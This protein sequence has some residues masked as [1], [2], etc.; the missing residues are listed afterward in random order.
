[1]LLLVG[2]FSSQVGDRVSG[3]MSRITKN[4]SE[5]EH[6]DQHVGKIQSQL[7]E[8]KALL[9]KQQEENEET[10]EAEDDGPE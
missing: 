2:F 8:I 4:K 10:A 7:A 5:I 1:M 6:V 9:V 3:V